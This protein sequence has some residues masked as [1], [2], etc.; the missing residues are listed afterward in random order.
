LPAC[1][2]LFLACPLSPVSPPTSLFFG[3]LSICCSPLF[4]SFLPEV[5]R[6]GFPLPAACPRL[7]ECFSRSLVCSLCVYQMRARVL[8]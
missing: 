4:C 8:N 1:L 5:S 2:P 3:C 7:P 6:I